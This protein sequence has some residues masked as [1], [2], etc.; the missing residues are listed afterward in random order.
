LAVL[1]D[2]VVEPENFFKSVGPGRALERA[3]EP[4]SD[5]SRADY[6]FDA[7]DFVL[8]FVDRK[9]PALWYSEDWNPCMGFHIDAS[10]SARREI[11]SPNFRRWHWR[12][13]CDQLVHSHVDRY[14]RTDPNSRLRYQDNTVR[15]L[16]VAGAH[17]DFKFSN[18]FTATQKLAKKM[19]DTPG[20]SLFLA[21]TG[22]SIHVER[23]RYF[24]GEIVRFLTEGP[25]ARGVS[26]LTALLLDRPEPE[27][28]P[29]PP[30][31]SFLMPLLLD[32]PAPVAP[33]LSFIP[34]LLLSGPVV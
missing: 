16:L 12:L 32:G 31:L 27:P 15:Q 9:S 8:P 22:H 13:A 17:D 14:V 25:R 34:P 33:D 10:R 24:A 21:K 30:D 26:F 4:E 5:R 11:Y 29:V 7:Y 28:V 2:R 6:F 1:G 20:R 23:P 19:V 18:I 3:Y